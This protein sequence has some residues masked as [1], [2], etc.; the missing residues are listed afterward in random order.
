MSSVVDVISEYADSDETLALA[1]DWFVEAA[2]YLY[3]EDWTSATKDDRRLLL[4]ALAR[5][6]NEHF[7]AA[8]VDDKETPPVS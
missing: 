4:C 7:G 8:A 3:G 2:R 1:L 6:A 5:A